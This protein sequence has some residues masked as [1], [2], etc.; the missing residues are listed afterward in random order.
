M[1]TRNLGGKPLEADAPRI[2]T[3]M[4][5]PWLYVNED[6]DIEI[7]PVGLDCSPIIVRHD[8]TVLFDSCGAAEGGGAAWIGRRDGPHVGLFTRESDNGLPSWTFEAVDGDN[9]PFISAGAAD[10][11]DQV[12]VVG[13][14]EK[15]LLIGHADR[16]NI[17]LAWQ[18]GYGWRLVVDPETFGRL[19]DEREI[20]VPRLASQLTLPDAGATGLSDVLLV[21]QA[22]VLYARAADGTLTAIMGA[23]RAAG[24]AHMDA[25]T[26]GTIAHSAT[27]GLAVGDSHTQYHLRTPATAAGQVFYS[28]NGSTF[29]AQLPLTGPDGWLVGADGL[30]LVV[31]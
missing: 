12:A 18:D 16:P 8:G 15:W 20:D 27:T 30:L 6:G 22:G 23:G 3:W 4:R 31:G 19:L 9:R 11:A 28:L 25:D 10:T 2:Q 29:T 24:H 5:F 26:G 7:R 14:Y 1:I 17:R 13:H 21:W